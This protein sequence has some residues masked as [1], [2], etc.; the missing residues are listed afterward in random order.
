MLREPVTSLP[1]AGS[2]HVP[3]VCAPSPRRRAVDS[4][5]GFFAARPKKSAPSIRRRR[6]DSSRCDGRPLR[7]E[8]FLRPRC[9]QGD[10]AAYKQ[11]FRRASDDRAV[12]SLSRSLRQGRLRS[13]SPCMPRR[14]RICTGHCRQSARSARKPA[15]RSTRRRRCQRDRDTCIDLLDLVLVMSV[16]PGFGGQAFIPGALGQGRATLSRDDRGPRRSTSK[17]MAA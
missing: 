14:G 3:A 15:C 9:H 2:T 5:V 10:A 16:N 8:H 7:A 6:L 12:R 11:D 17:W 4:G 1:H 13:S